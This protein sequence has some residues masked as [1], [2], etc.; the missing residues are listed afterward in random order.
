[1]MPTCCTSNVLSVSFSIATTAVSSSASYDESLPSLAQTISRV[2][3]LS[4]EGQSP[5]TT[6]GNLY[7]SCPMNGSCTD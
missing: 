7:I 6:L 3:D 4:N 2:N 1:M 5:G